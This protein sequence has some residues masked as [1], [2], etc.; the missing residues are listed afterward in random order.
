MLI[1]AGA[2][3]L[4]TL[5]LRAVHPLVSFLEAAVIAALARPAVVRLGRRIPQWLAV[6]ALT[7]VALLVLVALGALGFGELRSETSRFAEQAPRAAAD[8]E[9]RG[10]FGGLLRDIRFSDQVGTTSAQIARAFDLSGSDLPGLATAVGGRLSSAFIVWV[11]AV[12]LVFA[13]PAMVDGG[14]GLLGPRSGP[15]ARRVLPDAYRNTLR[16]LGYT[17]LRALTVGTIVTVTALALGLDMP[18]LL[19]VVAALLAYAPRLGIAAGFLPVALL[20]AVDGSAAP[21]AIVALALALQAI[22]VV[23]VQPRIDARSV[24][25][26]LLV[27]L[28]SIL[29][30]AG[31]YGVVGVFVGLTLGCLLVAT[32]VQVD[33]VQDAAA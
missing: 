4:G 14:I 3:L 15:I 6:L 12:M 8:L 24:R 27:T 16:Y 9:T 17:S 33:A 31:L 7:G 26:G 25:V 2:V 1:L 20:A 19:G 29:L 22:D 18:A 21:V 5:A 28:V 32:L 10:P 11:L 13:G 23:V 30:G